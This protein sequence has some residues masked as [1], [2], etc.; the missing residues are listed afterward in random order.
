M[1]KIRKCLDFCVD[2]MF[3]AH[4][5]FYFSIATRDHNS[6]VLLMMKCNFW[7]I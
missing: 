4:V 5:S 6:A 1:D 2:S 7:N 3:R